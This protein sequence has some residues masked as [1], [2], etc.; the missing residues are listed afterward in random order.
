MN[1][2]TWER[3]SSNRV[4][5]S[6]AA[7]MA[8]RG[9]LYEEYGY[10]IDE[11]KGMRIKRVV[12][13]DGEEKIQLIHRRMDEDEIKKAIVEFRRIVPEQSL[14]KRMKVIE[15]KLERK[16]WSEEYQRVSRERDRLY[17]ERL[18]KEKAEQERLKNKYEGI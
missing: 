8:G 3:I 4:Y 12:D 1:K 17:S 6:M 14:E 7:S 9:T 5:G 10:L 16:R 2:I 15:I 13:N 11:G 18:E